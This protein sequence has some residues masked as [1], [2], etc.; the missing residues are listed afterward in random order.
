M[1]KF[2]IK[3]FFNEQSRVTTICSSN[4]VLYKYFRISKRCTISSFVISGNLYLLKPFLKENINPYLN[5]ILWEIN[6]SNTENHSMIART[7]T[8]DTN[9]INIIKIHIKYSKYIQ[10]KEYFMHK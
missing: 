5:T 6:D 4:F 3:K 7:Y 8:N 9:S 10:L 1:L 2:I